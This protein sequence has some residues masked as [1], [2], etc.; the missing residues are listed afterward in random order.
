MNIPSRII[1]TAICL[2]S[3]PLAGQNVV[4]LSDIDAVKAS[5][6]YGMPAKGKAVSGEALKI[7]G[8]GYSDGLGVQAPCR[9]RLNLMGNSNSF[10]CK[11][12]VNDCGTDYNAPDLIKVPLVDGTMM[13]YSS[14][15]SGKSF[16]GIGPADG[17]DREGSV[18]FRI[19]GDGEELFNSGVMRSGDAAKPVELKIRGIETTELVVD[20]A[21]DGPC[22]DLADWGDAEFDYF[23]IKP[24]FADAESVASAA[25]ADESVILPLRR[26]IEELPVRPAR[27]DRPASDW[28]IDNASFRTIV[29]GTGDGKTVV[30][31][32]GL[33]SRSFRVIPNLATVDFF[34]AMSGEALLR[35]PSSEG[36]LKIDGREYSIGGLSGQF[37]YGYTLAKW[38]DGFTPIPNSFQVIDFEVRELQP[39]MEWKHKRWSLVKEWNPSGKEI[40][41]TIAGPG[42]LSGFRLYLHVAVYDGYPILSKWFE[43][44]N[45]TGYDCI[46]NEFLLEDLAMVESESIVDG[47]RRFRPHN[48]YVESD[49]DEG[50]TT[51]WEN[52][53][54]YTSQV[55]YVLG[56]P[57][58]LQVRLP[59]GPQEIIKAGESFTSFRNWMMPYDSEDRER[60]SLFFKRFCNQI[61]PWTSEN[62][63]FMHCTS[64]DDEVV[65]TAIDQCAETGYEMV[66][67]SFGSGLDMED[68]SDENIAKFKALADYAHSKGIELGGYSLYASRW[69]SDEVDLINPAT[70]KRGG[71]T[72]GSS[73]CICS[74]WGYDYFRKIR[75]FFEKTGFDVLEHDGSYSGD[76][77]ASTSHAH[78]NGLEDSQWKQHKIIDDLYSWMCASGIYLNVPDDGFRFVGSNKSAV[79]YREVNWSLPRDR[80]II[81]GRQNIYDGMWNRTA[82]NSWTFVPLVQYHGGG[83]A[84]TL[85]PLDEHLDAYKAH[86]IQNY[87]SGVQACYRGFRLYDT[88]RTRDCVKEVISWY[89]RYR[90]ILCS[91]VIH[92]R[93]PDGMDWDGFLHVNPGLEEKGFIMVF[94][95]TDEEITRTIT[96]PL[97]YT[98]L[99]D[100]ALVSEKDDKAKS[101]KLE[102]DYTVRLTVSIPA[103]GYNWF[104]VRSP[105]K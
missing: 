86:M 18:I 93:R 63:I 73:P 11:V 35:S 13:F 77:C 97:Y 21:G 48:I 102:R 91:D 32:N 65:R 41:F 2:A 40:V 69:I 99:T 16:L 58:R 100:K 92:L 68:E 81:L 1:A 42:N 75:T 62:P 47:P 12:G 51:H 6:Q 30:I 25:A 67:L 37:E 19:L 4:R 45:G 15:E 61:A 90:D 33:V 88:E 55:N 46:L 78:H 72:F 23:E 49:W 95:P 9:M 60:K 57:C 101:F 89:K 56:T 36:S 54:R 82:T 7:A 52:D 104:V 14:V 26:K 80:Q 50:F 20:D 31:G 105:R 87:G 43:L 70:G 5:Q 38:I 34:N 79:G 64:T 96:I 28:L 29:S 39:R 22:G 53:P 66:I 84:A 74:E 17:S 8:T 24:G 98:G 27:D 3:L 44:H 85:E 76:P 103:N 71:M 83:A 10:R 94:N 59:R